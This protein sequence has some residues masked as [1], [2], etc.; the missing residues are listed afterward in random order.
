M[1]RLGL[2]RNIPSSDIALFSAS[3]GVVMIIYQNDPSVINKNYLSVLTH[4]FG[5]N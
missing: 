1:L 5:R 2:V 3:M 4:V